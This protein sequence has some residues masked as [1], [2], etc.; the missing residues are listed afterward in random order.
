M[1]STNE[2]NA[3]DEFELDL[4]GEIDMEAK[5]KRG[6]DR[7]ATSSSLAGI[8][9]CR[10]QQHSVRIDDLS[11]K[12]VGV[13]LESRLPLNEE[14][15][16][17]IQLAVCGMDYELSMKCRIRHC[18]AI[19]NKTCHA[20]LMFIEMTPGTRETLELLIR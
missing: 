18:D 2:S 13:T 16:L 5:D 10:N 1:N 14:C 15:R 17:T 9:E 19:N 8:V 20:G 6:A 7:L 11:L 12:G 4:T 3:V